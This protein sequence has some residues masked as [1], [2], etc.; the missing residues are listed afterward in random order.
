MWQILL[1]TFILLGIAVLLLGFRIFFFK[2]GTFPN[3]HVGSNKSLS[4]KGI[5]CIQTQDRQ[6]QKSKKK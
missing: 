1:P 2:N 3:S 6:E 4:Q 5:N